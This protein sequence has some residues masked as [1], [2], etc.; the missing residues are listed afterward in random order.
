M[1][2]YLHGTLINIHSKWCLKTQWDSPICHGSRGHYV[3]K[4][5]ETGGTGQ[6]C[7][8]MGSMHVRAYGCLRSGGSLCTFLDTTAINSLGSISAGIGRWKDE[9]PLQRHTFLG[10]SNY[11]LQLLGCLASNSSCGNPISFGQGWDHRHRWL[12][13][14]HSPLK[15]V[16]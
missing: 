16:T 8:Q 10:L 6:L 1:T 5:T 3:K 9:A 7:T 13:L 11:S 14:S 12:W 4:G 2:Q 15:K